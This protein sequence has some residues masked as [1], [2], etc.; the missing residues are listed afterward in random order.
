MFFTEFDMFKH[1][2]LYMQ[3]LRNSGIFFSISK[4]GDFW[5]NHKTHN[6]LFYILLSFHLVSNWKSLN[7]RMFLSSQYYW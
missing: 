3:P 5:M 7:I 6:K 4:E 1:M 2:L